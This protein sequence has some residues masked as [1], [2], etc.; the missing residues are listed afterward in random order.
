MKALTF[1]AFAGN[2]VIGI[3]CDRRISL[4]G[5]YQ[6]SI[7][8]GILSFHTGAIRNGPLYSAFI[9]RIVRTFRLAGTTI[10][11]FISY[12]NSHNFSTLILLCQTKI[13]AVSHISAADFSLFLNSNKAVQ[14]MC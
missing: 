1:G 14:K 8:K 6:G 4:S 5:I 10:D 2:D 11:T 9:D 13:N 12:F 3:Y 7:Y